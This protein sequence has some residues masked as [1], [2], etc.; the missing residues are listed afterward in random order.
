VSCFYRNSKLGVIAY[1]NIVARE[2]A[3]NGI[4][5]NA[6]TPG[7]IASSLGQRLKGEGRRMLTVATATTSL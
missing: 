3:A 5:V 7:T 6:C 2:E 4:I 1:S